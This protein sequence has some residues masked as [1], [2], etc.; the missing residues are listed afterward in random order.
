[1]A[2]S[3]RSSSLPPSQFER[4]Q[5]YEEAVG[6]VLALDRVEPDLLLSATGNPM[7]EH[8]RRA[9]VLRLELGD[10][11]SAAS[12][13]PEGA[14]AVVYALLLSSDDPTRSGQ[15]ELL[16]QKLGS[17]VRQRVK[18]LLPEVQK[19][20]PLTK[21]PLID[22]TLP[23]LRHLG[24]DDYRRFAQAVQDQIEYDREIDLFEYTLQKILFRHLKPFYEGVPGPLRG[25][26][27][28]RSL[29]PECSVLLSALAHIGQEDEPA[30]LAAF[31]RG[32]GYLD[33]QEGGVQ[34]LA[35][36]GHSL[37]RVDA[38]L[39][40]LAEAAP[41]V[42]RNVLLACAQTVAADGQ[43]LCRE[44]ELLRAIADALDCPVPPFLEALGMSAR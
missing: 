12:H 28:L 8:I 5:R 27:S 30:M 26:S 42:K 2:S 21:L 14:Q 10:A 40:Q 37:A 38:A 1:M 29:L 20:D 25:Y 18:D 36:E 9:E 22:L 35:G 3:R 6:H 44:A 17:G 15:L 43:V 16:G 41:S 19:L 13:S 4:E 24:P 23:A 32:A 33:A 11:V 39:N 34:F 31:Q 7:V